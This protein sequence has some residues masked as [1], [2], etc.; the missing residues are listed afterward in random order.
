MFGSPVTDYT[1]RVIGSVG[2]IIKLDISH[3]L[4]EKITSIQAQ[5]G[6]SNTPVGID[7]E[8]SIIDLYNYLNATDAP[9]LA[10]NQAYNTLTIF[11]RTSVY[12]YVADT[13]FDIKG[14]R[15][16]QAIT[17]DT[18]FLDIPDRDIE[19][20]LLTV[21]RLIAMAKNNSSPETITSRISE[22]ETKIINE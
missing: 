14:Y 4:Y 7:T 12:D 1:D 5:V 17:S 9:D 10:Y 16:P 15:I 19:Y 3:L 8:V 21:K 18:D 13:R 6:A 22:L 20:F 11:F 2:Y